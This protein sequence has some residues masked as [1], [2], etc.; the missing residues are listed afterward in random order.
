MI[1]FKPISVSSHKLL[2]VSVCHEDVIYCFSLK[3]VILHI[4]CAPR[5][6]GQCQLIIPAYGG[7]GVFHL[8]GIRSGA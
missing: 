1:L 2:I 7:G 4:Y 6:G 8:S 5:S 3:I